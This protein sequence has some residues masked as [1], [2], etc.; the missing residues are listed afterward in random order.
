MVVKPSTPSSD[1]GCR[2]QPSDEEFRLIELNMIVIVPPIA[3]TAQMGRAAATVRRQGCRNFG[4]HEVVD[5]GLYHHFAGELH[6]WRLQ[7]EAEDGTAMEAAQST[8]KIAAR[9]TEEDA[10]EGREDGITQITMEHRHRAGQD[11]A[12]KAIAHDKLIAF[13]KLFDERFQRSEIVAVVT[14]PHDRI[15]PAP[16]SNAPIRALP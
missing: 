8:M 7:V 14:I 3:P 11:A 10:A 15:G 12:L 1:L 5:F 2:P 6:P 13:T 4:Y 9:T 16:G